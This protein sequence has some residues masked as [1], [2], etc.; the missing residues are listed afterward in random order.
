MY[1][2][3]V[4]QHIT[5]TQKTSKRKTPAKQESPLGLKKGV[6]Q[7]EE[8]STGGCAAERARDGCSLQLLLVPTVER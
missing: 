2:R 8:V 6:D 4:T 3:I 1:E 7:G 5:H